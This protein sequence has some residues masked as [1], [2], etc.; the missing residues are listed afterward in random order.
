MVFPEG[1]ISPSGRRQL[2]RPGL[3]WLIAKTGATPVAVEIHGAE[4]SRLSAKAGSHFW[5]KITVHF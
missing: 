5:P 1:A 3:D 2:D 4:N